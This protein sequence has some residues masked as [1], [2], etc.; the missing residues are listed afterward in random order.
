MVARPRYQRHWRL[1]PWSPACTL[2]GLTHSKVLSA[3]VITTGLTITLAAGLWLL[4]WLQRLHNTFRKQS[5]GERLAILRNAQQRPRPCRWLSPMALD[6]RVDAAALDHWPGPPQHL[7]LGF[8]DQQLLAS[9]LQAGA[10]YGQR[11]RI[12]V[13]G[14]LVAASAALF[15]LRTHAASLLVLCDYLR[16]RPRLRALRLTL[17]LGNTVPALLAFVQGHQALAASASSVRV[18]VFG[19][20]MRCYWEEAPPSGRAVGALDGVSPY[21]LAVAALL[22]WIYGV[23]VVRVL[24][25]SRRTIAA[26]GAVGAWPLHS[27]SSFPLAALKRCQRAWEASPGPGPF[28]WARRTAAG[29]ASRYARLRRGHRWRYL[30]VDFLL[31]LLLEIALPRWSVA[32]GLVLTW[33]TRLGQQA[34]WIWLNVDQ[35]RAQGLQLWPYG[36]I[37]ALGILALPFLTVVSSFGGEC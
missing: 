12:A 37:F 17:V 4:D 2:P 30:L 15:A 11:E 22:A 36:Q 25:V 3:P 27:P 7:I 8:G 23:G 19:F 32:V 20:P 1:S 9:L 33:A 24:C 34:L 18:R 10:A 13:G 21:S 31:R 26:R 29:A 16:A 6:C 35:V 14:F 28:S 5:L